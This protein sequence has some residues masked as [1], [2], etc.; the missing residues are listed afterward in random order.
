MLTLGNFDS[1][2]ML[3]YDM[4]DLIEIKSSKLFHF[5]TQMMRF[6]TR[7]PLTVTD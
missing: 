2:F 1:D 5:C 4:L 3:D 6:G 7:E